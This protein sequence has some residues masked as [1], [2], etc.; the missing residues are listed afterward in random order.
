MSD[1]KLI[2][3]DSSVRMI[4][5]HLDARASVTIPARIC[6]YLQNIIF[7]FRF[8]DSL[9]RFWLKYWAE[10]FDLGARFPFDLILFLEF[11]V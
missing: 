11:S 9:S 2:N 5:L 3:H 7:Q 4:F 10:G 8:E 1:G 6:I